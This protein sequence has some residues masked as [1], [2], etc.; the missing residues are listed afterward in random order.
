MPGKLPLLAATAGGL[1][2]GALLGA[3]LLGP[4][5]PA[6]IADRS[7]GGKR[8][9]GTAIA[10]TQERVVHR[11]A[12]P[13][14]D[15][16]AD[17]A[18]AIA[19]ETPFRRDLA[20]HQLAH[21][22]SEKALVSGIQRAAGTG[23]SAGGRA[24]ASGIFLQRLTELAPEQALAQVNGAATVDG[25]YFTRIVFGTWAETDLEAA[26]EGVRRVDRANLRQ[27]AG[28]TIV[29]VWSSLDPSRV[30]WIVSRLPATYQAKSARRRMLARE[31]AEDPTAALAKALQTPNRVSR[32]KQVAAVAQLWAETD[33]YAA[34]AEGAMIE[35]AN[36]RLSFERAVVDRWAQRDPQA[37]IAE[38]SQQRRSSERGRML[39]KILGHLTP[40]DPQGAL[41]W[42]AE[43]ESVQGHTGYSQAV[44]KQ[45][46]EHDAQLAADQL[47]RLSQASAR[48]DVIRTIAVA[49][50]RQ[51]P[52]SVLSWIEAL[53][54]SQE[55]T[56]A[57]SAA[58]NTV[59]L[60][61]AAAAMTMLQGAPPG[62]MR[63]SAIESTVNIL[64]DRRPDEAASFLALLPPGSQQFDNGLRSLTYQWGR[65]DPYAALTW[66]Q[67]LPD[68]QRAK[69]LPEAIGML[70]QEDVLAAANLVETLSGTARRDAIAQVARRYGRQ[71][72]AA[73]MAWIRRFQD[74]PGYADSLS[75]VLNAWA[76]SDPR[77]AMGAL[78]RVDEEHVA[79]L[80]SQ[81]AS[82][83]ARQ[84][85]AAAGAWIERLPTAARAG[86]AQAVANTWSR[87][88]SREAIEWALDLDREYGRDNAI[89]TAINNAIGNGLSQQTDFADE[90]LDWVGE[91]ENTMQ[92]ESTTI[93]VLN[94]IAREDPSAARAGLQRVTL[95]PDRRAKVLE[96]IEAY[97]RSRG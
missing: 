45:L 25:D 40:V 91:I 20:L 8:Q 89:S 86:A 44:L 52:E 30:D 32:W 85:P 72:P 33:P 14:A 53:P 64:A 62:Q 22:S 28:D 70:A 76:Q 6:A 39:M 96:R 31:V 38:I 71:Q 18:A 1:A 94:A 84:D 56:T 12:A 4:G 93:N 36:A 54:A 5:E 88:D 10:V 19:L 46:A 24:A 2:V 75:S 97:E 51:Q 59:A 35:D 68:G 69:A 65:S 3:R 47:S 23:Q 37:A 82:Q 81:M 77:A 63:N 58:V 74:E 67:Q 55:R 16:P 87:T 29:G 78:D 73:A 92:R 21:E 42:A 49:L 34:L 7:A 26:I 27:V 60:A 79:R 57:F 11:E 15:L 95:S 66:A 9:P 83:W 50:A 61:D 41:R 48:R 43:L 90:A 80:A 17:I 13:A